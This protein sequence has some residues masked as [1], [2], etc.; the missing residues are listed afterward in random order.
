MQEMRVQFLGRE[1]PLEEKKATH[2]RNPA[3]KI[4]W[5]KKLGRL[6]SMRSQRNQTQLSNCNN[7]N[8]TLKRFTYSQRKEI[9]RGWGPLGSILEFCPLYFLSPSTSKAVKRCWMRTRSSTLRATSKLSHLRFFRSINVFDAFMYSFSWNKYWRSTTSLALCQELEIHDEQ[10]TYDP[11]PCLV[12]KMNQINTKCE[13]VCSTSVKN[14]SYTV[15][16][17]P[18]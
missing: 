2:S 9:I 10:E 5:T 16:W 15:L 17:K 3:W 7:N 6:Q 4:A 1:D 14:V 18:I 13:T 11:Y 12:G 8:I